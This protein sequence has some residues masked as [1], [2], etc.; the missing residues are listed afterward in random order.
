M[1]QWRCEE[2][3]QDAGQ[4]IQ[5]DGVWSYDDLEMK[6]MGSAKLSLVSDDQVHI[7]HTDPAVQHHSQHQLTTINMA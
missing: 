1:Q 5:K 6:E 3:E 2:H 4:R 7:K